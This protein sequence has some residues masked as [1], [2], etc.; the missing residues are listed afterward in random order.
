MADFALM[1]QSDN[2]LT[3]RFGRDNAYVDMSQLHRALLLLM[4]QQSE[5]ECRRFEVP[6]PGAAGFE[7][8]RY[9]LGSGQRKDSLDET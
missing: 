6:A 5:I 7:D 4:F 8:R 3:H 1:L 2:Q 9:R